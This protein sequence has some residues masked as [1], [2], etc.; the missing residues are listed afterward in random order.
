MARFL[1]YQ[2]GVELLDRKKALHNLV[3]REGSKV[4]FRLRKK[5]LKALD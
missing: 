5:I 2:K 3:A 4:L 1:V